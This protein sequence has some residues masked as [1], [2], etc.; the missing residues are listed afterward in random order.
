[1]QRRNILALISILSLALA[2]L[3]CGLFGDASAPQNDGTAQPGT[4]LENTTGESQTGQGEQQR[5]EEGGFAFRTVPG[6]SF[7]SAFGYVTMQA[8]DADPDVGPVIVLIGGAKE[9]SQSPEQLYESFTNGLESNVQVS[10]SRNVTVGGAPGIMADIGGT[11]KSGQELAGRIVLVTVSPAQQFSMIGSAPKDRWQNETGPLF[12]KVLDSISFFEPSQAS[13]ETPEVPDLNPTATPASQDQSGQIRQWA[14]SALAS[15]EY[16]SPDWSASQATGSPNTPDCSDS[17]TA[18]AAAENNTVD[19]IVLAYDLPVIPLQVNVVQSYSP[20]QVSKVELIDE[21]GGFHEI[22]TGQ[23][24]LQDT[25]P[26]TLSIPVGGAAYR[27]KGVRVTIDQSV[28]GE[29]SWNE[30]DAVELVGSPSAP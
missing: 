21:A 13:L 16:G 1:M 19:W 17:P 22:Y 28:I 23:P 9:E 5:S 14:S 20:S 2:G 3:A 27:A 24:Q 26:Y 29:S 11:G 10:N 25:C 7:D 6:Y 18:W 15:T 30:I 12:E 8:P 4:N